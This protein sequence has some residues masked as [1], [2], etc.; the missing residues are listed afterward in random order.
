MAGE[1]VGP[2]VGARV[3]VSSANFESTEAMLYLRP[4]TFSNR[5][6]AFA[7]GFFAGYALTPTW[8][9]EAA[10][11]HLGKYSFRPGGEESIRETV[12]LTTVSTSLTGRAPLNDQLAAVAKLGVAYAH[13]AHSV[14]GSYNY[15]Y[16]SSSVITYYSS[17][18]QQSL[19]CIR[20]ALALGLDWKLNSALRAQLGV[21]TYYPAINHSENG[22]MKAYAL[23]FGLYFPL[24][25]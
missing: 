18:K 3:G 17:E 13:A 1:P 24:P 5:D 12:E 6:N 23:S 4:K 22:K 14:Q 10:V 7:A 11:G 25:F 2:Y 21:E 16:N 19:D 8:G 9:V 20:S 15:N